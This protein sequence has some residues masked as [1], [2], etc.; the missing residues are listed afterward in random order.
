MSP[1]PWNAIHAAA[2]HSLRSQIP[3]WA[4]GCSGEHLDHVAEGLHPT[5]RPLR[6]EQGQTCGTCV[7][8]RLT[9][10]CWLASDAG[11]RRVRREWWACDRWME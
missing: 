8:Y 6:E 11:G 4:E 10:D 1:H 7:G 5:G 3:W 9:H 2:R